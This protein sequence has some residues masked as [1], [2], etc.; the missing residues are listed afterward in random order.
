MWQRVEHFDRKDCEV[1]ALACRCQGPRLHKAF[2]LWDEERGQW[3][4]LELADDGEPMPLE[5][6]FVFR[7]PDPPDLCREPRNQAVRH[8]G[9]NQAGPIP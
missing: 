2:G 7:I 1:V 4:T 5:P 8:N 9:G 3:L 6:V